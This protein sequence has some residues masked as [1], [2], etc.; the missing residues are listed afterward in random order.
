ERQVH[1]AAAPARHQR[2]PAGAGPATAH[3][4]GRP[5]RPAE[6]GGATMNPRERTMALTLG[7][8]VVL[9]FGGGA[10]WFFLIGPWLETED[11]IANYTRDVEAKQRQLAQIKKDKAKLERWRQLSL[12]GEVTVQVKGPAGG[13]QEKGEQYYDLQEK[14]IDYLKNALRKHGVKSD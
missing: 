7:V 10:L 4:A 8:L 6:R 12:P 2:Q 11:N 14:Y 1:D 5:D 9:V 13:A 3:R